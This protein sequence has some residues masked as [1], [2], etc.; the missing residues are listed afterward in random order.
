M[1]CIVLLQGNVACSAPKRL[2]TS[3][4]GLSQLQLVCCGCRSQHIESGSIGDV[5]PCR[6]KRWAWRSCAPSIIPARANSASNAQMVP[7]MGAGRATRNARESSWRRLT[8]LRQE[9]ISGGLFRRRG[10]GESRRQKRQQPHHRRISCGIREEER[11]GGGWR[12][13]LWAKD[14]ASQNFGAL[15][16]CRERAGSLGH[17]QLKGIVKLRRGA[18]CCQQW[19]VH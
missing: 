2:R 10:D 8:V 14:A 15:A 4:G 12:W 7:R 19:Q 1:V 6:R 11:E 16:A 5:S 17:L 18:G 3:S 13:A 9:G